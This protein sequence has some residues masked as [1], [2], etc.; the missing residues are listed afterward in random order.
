MVACNGANVCAKTTIPLPF[1]AVSTLTSS[2]APTLT[3]TVL[4]PNTAFKPVALIVTSP[5]KTP[6]N[7]STDKVAVPVPST[8]DQ[9]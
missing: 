5:T 3:V 8:S 9:T 2:A 6:V 7:L 1:A 4:V